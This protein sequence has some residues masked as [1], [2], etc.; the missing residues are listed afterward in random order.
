MKLKWIFGVLFLTTFVFKAYPQTNNIPMNKEPVVLLVGRNLTVMEILKDELLRYDRNI[1]YG[2]SMELIEP[3]LNKANINLII[4][5]AGIPDEIRDEMQKNIKVLHPEIPLYMIERTA[6]G[7]PAKMIHFVNEK[8]ILWK[9]EQQI[10]V[11]SK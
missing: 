4:I 7:S 5:G 8:V 11:M 1:V 3:I 9:I 6:D 2:N 10:G